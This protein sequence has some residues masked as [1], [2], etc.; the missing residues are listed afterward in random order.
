MN[1][2]IPPALAPCGVWCGACHSYQKTCL[3][4]ASNDHNQKRNSKWDCRIRVCAYEKEEVDFCMDCEKF[5]CKI[6]DAK[7]G[8]SREGDPRFKYRHEIKENFIKLKEFGPEKYILYQQERYACRA[9]GG[10]VYF[11]HYTC[12]RCGQEQ[13]VK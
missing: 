9:C 2:Q 11:Y 4:C 8:K 7:L 1:T 12:S 3:G 10:Q 13:Q 5:P 6:H